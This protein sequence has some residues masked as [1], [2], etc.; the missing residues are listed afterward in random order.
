MN[1]DLLLALLNL[2]QAIN[3]KNNSEIDTIISELNKLDI[4]SNDC[5]NYIKEYFK[6]LKRMNK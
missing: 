1:N 4:S 5:T 2:S 3:N 6:D